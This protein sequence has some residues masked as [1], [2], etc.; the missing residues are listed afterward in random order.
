MGLVLPDASEVSAEELHQAE[1]HLGLSDLYYFVQHIIRVGEGTPLKRPREEIEP[2]TRWLQKPRP[3][4]VGKKDAGNAFSLFLAA[5]LKPP[6]FRLTQ[7][8]ALSK[9]P[10]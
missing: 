1:A 3:E 7:P 8:G 5:P 2:I 6:W 10:T 4:H 9:I